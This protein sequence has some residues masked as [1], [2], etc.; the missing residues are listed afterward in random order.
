MFFHQYVEIIL[1]R[2]LIDWKSIHDSMFQID[3]DLI[4]KKHALTLGDLARRRQDP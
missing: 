3:E 1:E 4:K 2:N